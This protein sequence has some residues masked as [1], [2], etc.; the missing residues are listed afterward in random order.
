MLCWAQIEEILK[1]QHVS[2]TADHWKSDA[3]ESYIAV[4]AHYIDEKW[5]YHRVVLG[6]NHYEGANHSGATTMTLLRD[7]WREYELDD[8]DNIVAVVTDTASNMNSMGQLL[9]CPHNYCCNH[10]IE[11]TTKLAFTDEYMP[12]DTDVIGPAK[13]LVNYIHGN[14]AATHLLLQAQVNHFALIGERKKKPLRVKVDVSTRWW[15]TFATI[16]RLLVLKPQ[17]EYLFQTNPDNKFPVNL[18]LTEAQWNRLGALKKLLEPFRHAQQQL[19]GERY[20]TSSFVLGYMTSLRKHLQDLWMDHQFD[21]FELAQAMILDFDSRWGDGEPGTV[22]HQSDARGFRDRLIGIPKNV[23]ASAALDP[24]TKSLVGLDATD[25][26]S[27]WDHIGVLLEEQEQ[28]DQAAAQQVLVGAPVEM[29]A[30]AVHDE[31]DADDG[32][33]DDDNGDDI[34]VHHI[35]T[36]HRRRMLEMFQRGGQQQAIG[37][38]HLQVPQVPAHLL[39]LQFF[40]QCEELCLFGVNGEF[41]SPL[42]WWAAHQH[43]YPRIARLARKYLAAP[44]SSASSERVFTAAGLTIASSIVCVC[45]CVCVYV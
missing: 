39:E 44:A 24:R 40:R 6:C 29:A 38:N 16:E 7:I 25:R 1:G 36:F 11:R 30:I 18:Q 45:V 35:L 5:K 33:D 2:I 31:S 8:R 19:E 21:L 27:V 20:I 15:S 4:T 17:L 23:L 13:A 37:N 12:L 43:V 10:L 28:A 32:N 34:G 42:E 26:Q 3:N 14:E 9:H 22:Y 41:S